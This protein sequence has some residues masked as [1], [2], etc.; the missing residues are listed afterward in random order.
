M[1]QKQYED[2]HSIA[3]FSRIF[4]DQMY[5][6]MKNSGLLDKGF[7]LDV[8]VTNIEHLDGT[9]LAASVE[10]QPWIIDV[11]KKKYEENAVRQIRL[12][13]EKEWRVRNDP[14]AKTGSLPPEVRIER[15]ADDSKRVAE[16]S[17]KPYAPDGLWISSRDDNPD[18]VGGQ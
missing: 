12:A 1:D 11:G 15:K 18:V 14:Y 10:I 9:S 13:G 7:H 3:M 16:T 2:M 4:A 6:C 17:D 5:K 8:S